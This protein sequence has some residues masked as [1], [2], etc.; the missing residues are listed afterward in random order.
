[1]ISSDPH[2]VYELLNDLPGASFLLDSA[3]RITY[4]SDG[5]SALTGLPAP[6]LGQVEFFDL[7][8]EEDRPQARDAFTEALCSQQTHLQIQV[9]LHA[10]NASY[11]WAELDL[12]LRLRYKVQGASCLG[13]IRDA[14]RQVELA[15]K[16]VQ[17]QREIVTANHELEKLLDY[18]QDTLSEASAAFHSQLQS[19]ALNTP[20]YALNI[21]N[22]PS[23][24]L[25]G[26][27][28]FYRESAHG[29]LLIGLADAVG[30]GPAAAL[31]GVAVKAT[32][33]SLLHVDEDP[34]HLLLRLN[35]QAGDYLER[36]AYFTLILVEVDFSKRRVSVF[37]CGG[38]PALFFSR[39]LITLYA[40][41]PPI[42]LYPATGFTCHQLSYQPLAHMIMLSDGWLEP[43]SADG[44]IAQIPAAR[45]FAKFARGERI[46][47]LAL[48]QAV[49]EVIADAH[50]V[51]D[52][53]GVQITLKQR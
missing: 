30:H 14:R 29:N 15:E 36:G 39:Q 23:Y 50:F 5:Y 35:E 25:G 38:P 53:S 37:N 28:F 6:R 3:S 4:I 51:D 43:Q 26:D 42:G 49:L 27:V 20:Y 41:N 46:S 52:L 47:E 1:M 2:N 10:A 9:R 45:T 7:V 40:N 22:R 33:L 11:I 21:V 48:K 16:L 13:V 12:I 44:R 8:I 34:Q 19:T 24:F 31:R 32:A 18:S 17:T